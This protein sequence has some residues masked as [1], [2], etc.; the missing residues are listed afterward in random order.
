MMTKAERLWSSEL[1][2]RG[3]RLLPDGGARGPR[4]ARTHQLPDG[5]RT[6]DDLY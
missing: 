2:E 4:G 6:N 1:P 3:R 5:V